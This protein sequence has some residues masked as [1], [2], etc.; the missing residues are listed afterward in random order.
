MWLW[1]IRKLR[2]EQGLETPEL[3]HPLL[4]LPMADPPAEMRFGVAED[5]LFPRLEAFYQEVGLP[6]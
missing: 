3:K 2:G 6:R 1:A 5:P 4:D